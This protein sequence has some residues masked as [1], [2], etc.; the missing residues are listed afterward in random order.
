[1]AG[2]I[3]RIVSLA[4]FVW[5][6]FP[7][8]ARANFQ[9]TGYET[10]SIQQIL[11]LWPK[12]QPLLKQYVL[13]QGDSGVA[14]LVAVF[15]DHAKPGEL[16][17]TA[18]VI[19][20]EIRAPV[21]ADLLV[22]AFGEK[23]SK[24]G[25]ISMSRSWR[26]A[27]LVPLLANYLDDRDVCGQ[28]DRISTGSQDVKTVDWYASDGAVDALERITGLKFEAKSDLFE[29]GHRTTSPWIDWWDKN[30]EA[31]QK[32]P[33]TF[34]VSAEP[35]KSNV[36][37]NHYPC[38]VDKIAISRN[39]QR[40]FSGSASYDGRVR[41]WDLKTKEQLWI[42]QGRQSDITGAAFSP[43]G[44]FIATSSWDDSVNL[45]DAATGERL[46]ILLLE[47]GVDS[48]AFSPDGD[49]LAAANDRGVIQL[50]ST[51]DWH[52]IREL[53]NGDMTE[54]IAFSPDGKM[55]AA[56]TFKL[57]KLWDVDS[58]V[59]IRDLAIRQAGTP[60]QVADEWGVEAQLWKM[61]WNVAFSSDGKHLAT[62]SGAAVEV[63]D[64]SNGKETAWKP[65]HGQVVGL[66]YS[67]D[68]QSIVWGNDH[69]EIWEWNPA[70]HKTRRIK[71]FASMGDIGITADGQSVFSPGAGKTIE[72][73][74][75]LTG[76]H[77][78]EIACH[79]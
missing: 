48:V 53:N 8:L 45:W 28:I 47:S 46:R 52:V 33:Q 72:I 24:C 17:H 44:K 73:Y 20:N 9:D 68:G 77:V 1:M 27:R 32:E 29:I 34:V 67:P 54:G 31:F 23:D 15:N 78:G 79:D 41:L 63:W 49:L 5:L 57:V 25:A 13:E 11:E 16:R 60:T 59:K 50:R 38:T 64:V 4:L 26:D 75:L 74:S 30:R 71:N 39:G 66:A 56:A 43:D 14:E 69:D 40:V 36:S 55:L 10:L 37:K 21:T 12:H 22:E 51:E 65:S 3:I 70:A 6:C 18:L 35:V 58:G 2:R 19:L 42:Q 61:A 62:G 76:K 7:T